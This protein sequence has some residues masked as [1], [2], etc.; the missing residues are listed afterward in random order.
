ARAGGHEREA[1]E[2][3]RGT[4]QVEAPRVVR[5]AA[6][7]QPRAPELAR[8][9][10]VLPGLL[11]RVRS[12]QRLRPGQRAEALLAFPHRVASVRAVS[13]DAHAH[14]AVQPQ[15]ALAA[16]HIQRLTAL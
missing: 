12:A 10:Q 4:L 14:V 13:L 2:H 6:F 1:L 9:L 11:D 5:V 15:G 3:E 8:A 7:G 16:V